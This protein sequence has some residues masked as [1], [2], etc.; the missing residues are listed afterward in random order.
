MFECGTIEFD[1]V[2]FGFRFDILGEYLEREGKHL[3][4]KPKEAR[5]FLNSI[6][7]IELRN[8]RYF[9]RSALS[10]HVTKLVEGERDNNAKFH[11]NSFNGAYRGR[12]SN[13]NQSSFPRGVLNRRKSVW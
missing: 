1:S 8:G 2:W 9:N 11:P 13:H 7:T 12:Y 6:V 3:M 4:S 5:E 10:S